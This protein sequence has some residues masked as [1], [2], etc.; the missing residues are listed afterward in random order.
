MTTP[1]VSVVVATYRRAD[2][3]P[4]LLAA[5]DAQ[6][7]PASD[8]EVIVIENASPDDTSEVLE[9]LRAGFRGNLRILHMDAN[10]GPAP[11]RNVGIAAATAPIIAFTDDDCIPEPDWLEAGL[12]TM[13]DRVGVAQGRTLPAGPTSAFSVTQDIDRLTGLYETCNLFARTD[14]LRSFGGFDESFG[15]FGEDTALGWGVRG[16]GWDAVFVA[17]AVVRHEVTE[18]PFS[19]HLRRARMYAAF[20][21]LARTVPGFRREMFWHRLFL[22]RRTASVLLAVA[23][24]AAAVPV[25]WLTLLAVVPWFWHHRRSVRAGAWRLFARQLAFDLAV[26]WALVVGSIRH[27]SVVL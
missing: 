19:W 24:V 5:L 17:D 27:R 1:R 16:A 23:G 8:Y 6:T 9:S 21:K 15:F 14:V 26:E 4:A 18:P 13:V 11:A 10:A 2:R 7:L 3:L 22:R 12:R 25:H 20:P